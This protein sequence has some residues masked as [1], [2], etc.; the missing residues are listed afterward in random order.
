MNWLDVARRCPVVPNNWR[1]FSVTVETFL[2][3]AGAHHDAERVNG[4]LQAIRSFYVDAGWYRDLDK[5]DYYAAWSLQFYPIF[6]LLWDGD[7]LPEIRDEFIA[8]NDEFLRSFPHLLSRRGEIPRWGRSQIYRFGAAAPLAAAFLRSDAPA[9][10]PGF[11]RRLCSG[12]MLQ[13]IRHPGFLDRGLP[14]LGW[15]GEDPGIVDHYSGVASPYWC[16]KL[17]V[18][19][20]LPESS[21][22]W[23]AQENE[24]FWANPPREVSLGATGLRVMHDGVTGHTRLFAPQTIPK[25]DPRY[26]A[27]WFDTTDSS[28]SDPR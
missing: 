11:A 16:A 10:D 21:P 25:G 6:W 20:S 5:F 17:F 8:R 26:Q 3:T 14:S 7:S 22:F 2:K 1:W 12:A 18:A 19:L 27:R 24:G 15:F 13:F 23:S 28:W 9:V 4:H